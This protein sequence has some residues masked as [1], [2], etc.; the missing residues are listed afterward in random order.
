MAQV[1]NNFL[2]HVFSAGNGI[3]DGKQRTEMNHR[4]KLKEKRRQQKRGH[5]SS[6]GNKEVE[7]CS[8]ENQQNT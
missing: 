7:R 4:Q 2:C 3:R 6:H 5:E 8:N 1:T